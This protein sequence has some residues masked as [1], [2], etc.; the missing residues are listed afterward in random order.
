MNQDKVKELLLNIKSDVE[1]FL[2]IFTGK[3]SSKVDGLYNR[4]TSEILI[5]N[6]NFNN[7][8]SM[9]YTAIHEFAHHIQFTELEPEAKTKHHSVIFWKTFHKLLKEAESMNI[10]VNIF[11]KDEKFLILTENIKENYLKQNGQLMKEFG[12]LLIE[13]Y[14]LCQRNHM[15]FE[16]YV[17]R[18]LC[19]NRIA[20]KNIMRVYAMDIDPVIGFDN[21]NIVAKIKNRD[22]RKCAEAEFK[23]GLSVIEVKSNIQE[24]KSL[25]PKPVTVKKLEKEKQRVEKS[26]EALQDKLIEIDER[27]KEYLD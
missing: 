26:I 11:K 10:Y 14:D 8:N 15:E 21:M 24:T 2:V 4:E 16:D 19:M 6:R 13:A 9:L 20:A 5:H 1:D 17:D 27:I 7:D 3:E 12:K 18:E 23:H 22:Q 25:N